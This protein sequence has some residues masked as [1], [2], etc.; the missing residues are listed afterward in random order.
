MKY[1]NILAFLLMVG[2][3]SCGDKFGTCTTYYE[4]G[5]TVRSK[6][7][8]NLSTNEKNG[9]MRVYKKNGD[10]WKTMVYV[11]NMLEDT[12]RF[13]YSRTGEPLKTVPMQKD[14]RH[15]VAKEYFKNGKV[16]REQPYI[17]NLKEG[18]HRIYDEEGRILSETYYNKGLKEKIAITNFEDVDQLHEKISYKQNRRYG[19]YEKYNQQGKLVLKG[20]YR[21]GYPVGTWR[22]RTVV[23]NLKDA[24]PSELSYAYKADIEQLDKY[25]FE[26]L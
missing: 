14:K 9:I 21:N 13:F 19:A 2:L 18:F 23:G 10:L 17:N 4:D 8:C 7:P 6:V 5:E 25:L 22:F 26:H 24:S 12:T 20:E 15:G 3:S 11:D 1:L 16:K